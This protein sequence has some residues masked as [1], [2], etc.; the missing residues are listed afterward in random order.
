[1]ST[2]RAP[3]AFP[4]AAEKLL[5]ADFVHRLQ[6]R[7]DPPLRI[8][9]ETWTRHE[10]AAQL[11]CLHTAAARL[12]TAAANEIGAKN[13]RD[14][15]RRSTPYTFARHGLGPTTMYVL[16]R[17]FESQGLDAEAWSHGGTA[18]AMVT[19]ETMKKREAK[20]E[21]RTREG[22]RKR[23]RSQRRREHETAVAAVVNT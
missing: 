18:G 2:R 12:L 17:L 23:K 1:M 3:S 11:G 7:D 9:S 14:L 13:V 21:Q 22:E 4:A 20:A 15:Y 8:G 19:F 10:I 16:W 5:G 6:N